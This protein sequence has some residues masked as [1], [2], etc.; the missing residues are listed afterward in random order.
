MVGAI[1][2]QEL[3]VSNVLCPEPRERERERERESMQSYFSRR[4]LGSWKWHMWL[5]WKVIL[6]LFIMFIEACKV[7]KWYSFEDNKVFMLSCKEGLISKGWE[8]AFSSWPLVLNIADPGLW[9]FLYLSSDTSFRTMILRK[10]AKI[11]KKNWN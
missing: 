9:F 7:L 4:N 1:E 11:G 6:L 5:N 3:A 8:V 2:I 10:I